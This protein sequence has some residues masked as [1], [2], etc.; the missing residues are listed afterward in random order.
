MKI[1]GHPWSE[2][3][4]EIADQYTLTVQPFMGGIRVL[5]HESMGLHCFLCRR[6]FA[7]WLVDDRVWKT[8]PKILH[9]KKICCNCFV[10][11][12]TFSKLQKKAKAKP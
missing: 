10:A 4:K 1:F 6:P 5:I 3:I 7:H 9:D 11:I 12:R 2:Q 8:L